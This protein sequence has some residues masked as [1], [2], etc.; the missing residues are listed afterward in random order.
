MSVIVALVVGAVGPV[1][2]SVLPAAAW[3]SA[4][5]AA[6]R[7]VGPAR[8]ADTR[9]GV[10]Y[11]R[12]DEHTVRVAVSGRAGVPADAVAV[13]LTV[14]MADSA[15]DGF[16]TVW[17]SGCP[18]PT[19]STLNADGP[20]QTVANGATVLLG[21][22][23]AIDVF[24][25]VP[26]AIV[27]DV[28]GAYVPAARSRAGR[29]VA[30][31]P[32]RLIDSR[33]GLGPVVAGGRLSVPLGDTVP[34]DAAAVVVNL[35]VDQALGAGFWRA[36]GTG[37]DEPTASVLNTDERGQTRASLTV[38]PLAGRASIDV[39]AQTG[40]HV[41]VDL[42]GWFTGS[43]APDTTAGLFAP[44]APRRV[45][46][47]RSDAAPLAA[48]GQ[49]HVHVPGGVLA[50]VG[51]L[52]STDGIGGGYLAAR[53]SAAAAVTVSSVNFGPGQTV[54]NQVIAVSDGGV[55]V[56][57]AGSPTQVVLDL[58]GYFV[59]GR[60]V[61]ASDDPGA[62][63]SGRYAP[64]VAEVTATS[65]P[66]DVLVPTTRDTMSPANPINGRRGGRHPLSA[67]PGCVVDPSEPRRCLVA[68]LDGLGFAV[69][70]GS[71][72]E[73]ERRLHL[74]IAVVQ[75]DAGLAP[76]GMGDRALYEYLGIWPGSAALGADE[77]RVIGTSQQGRPIVALRYGSGPKV[78]MVVGV[79]HGDEE[80][81]LRVLLRAARTAWPAG[82]TVWVV[83]TVNPDGLAL[84]TRLLANRADP[85]RQ[86]PAQREQA[87]LAAFARAIR[88]VTSVY[89]HQNYGWVGGSGASM[90]PA[91]AYH[92]SAP[93]G[94]LNRSGDCA[95]GFLWCPID[96]E[97]GSSSVLVEL[98]DVVTPAMVHVHA[99][100]LVAALAA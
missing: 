58:S 97:V 53:P 25:S 67:E 78:A 80:A 46:D 39:T 99:R 61:A 56:E 75:W 92:A 54:A 90:G 72:A 49:V 4:P 45:M 15:A 82:T 34:D 28:V 51:N 98:P 43:S 64:S 31:P 60:E 57:V 83:P 8:L 40:G 73:R 70:A 94:L 91:T 37:A 85:N 55:V 96:A 47:T 7:A 87:A 88:P 95:N 11:R 66:A 89:F 21:V 1:T 5:T 32:Q 48:G 79:T 22:D 100:A 2:A 44:A 17:P 86:A 62:D 36:F 63:A 20:G 35:T 81:G 13:V 77:V 50:V 16:V 33:T 19:V 42:V 18:Q 6:Y 12:V 23:G 71:A 38:V 69:A 93:L 41:V 14:T 27:V 24:A 59:D 26:A 74:A 29:F 30:V 68:T 10:G 65:V 3:V 84:D 76:T 9:T 52:T